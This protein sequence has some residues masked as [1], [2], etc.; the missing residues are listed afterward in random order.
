MWGQPPLDF[1][2]A[3]RPNKVRLRL[4]TNQRSVKDASPVR[5]R[6]WLKPQPKQAVIA[7]LRALST[8][9]LSPLNIQKTVVILGTGEHASFKAAENVVAVASNE[10]IRGVAKGPG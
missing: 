8:Q 9:I 5:I 10:A 3:V 1:A 6:I 7:L 2:Q 4:Q